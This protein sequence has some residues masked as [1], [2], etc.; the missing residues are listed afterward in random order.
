MT[1]MAKNRFS[2]G[3]G[4]SQRQLRVAELIR[5]RLST[6]LAQGDVHDPELD[7]IPITV[8]EVRTTPDLKVATAFILPL[9]GDDPEG[10]LSALRRNKHEIRRIVSRG[11]SLK[12]APEIRF[13]L[14]ETYDRLDDTRRLFA[15]DNVRRDLD[16]E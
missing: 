4:P 11:L 16:N 14:D 7:S 9:G 5:R 13:V 3:P 1:P 10:A 12:F 8:G 6:V 15:Q 2:E